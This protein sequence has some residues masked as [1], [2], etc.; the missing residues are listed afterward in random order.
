MTRY[1]K[2]CDFNPRPSDFFVHDDCEGDSDHY[3]DLEGASEVSRFFGRN[4]EEKDDCD[5]LPYYNFNSQKWG[6][7]S[8]MSELNSNFSDINVQILTRMRNWTARFVS[9]FGQQLSKLG[10]C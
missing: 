7:I 4:L 2:D 9:R 8:K 5:D 1:D 3:D 10:D 6:D